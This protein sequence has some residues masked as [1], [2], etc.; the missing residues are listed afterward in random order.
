MILR[1]HLFH[2]RRPCYL[3]APLP[4]QPQPPLFPQLAMRLSESLPQPISA[5]TSPIPVPHI[6]YPSTGHRLGVVVGQAYRSTG[7]C[8][9]QAYCST[10][11]DKPNSA[12]ESSGQAYLSN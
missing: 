11:Y 2:L 7:H 12:P 1:H 5:P 4:L 6:A 8:I 9:G 10:G 3:S